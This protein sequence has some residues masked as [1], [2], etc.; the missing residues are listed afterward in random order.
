M[1]SVVYLPT[2]ALGQRL[3]TFK[4]DWW[5]SEYRMLGIKVNC[6]CD[7]ILVETIWYNSRAVRR[8]W[9]WKIRCVRLCSELN[10][11][12]AII[13]IPKFQVMRNSNCAHCYLCRA[14]YDAAMY[15]VFIQVWLRCTILMRAWKSY[16][17]DKN[18]VFIVGLWILSQS[19]STMHWK[20]Y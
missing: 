13:G 1:P 11:P 17:I 7:T 19:I 18:L 8:G 4:V 12:N 10:E 3:C 16:W 20:N 9:N 6:V 5:S 14:E 15:L 2:I